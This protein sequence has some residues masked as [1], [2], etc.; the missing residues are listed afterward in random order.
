MWEKVIKIIWAPW[1]IGYI[2]KAK[3]GVKEECFLC[4]AWKGIDKDK[5]GVYKGKNAMIIMN[6]YP[7]NSG[8]IMIF[9]KTHTAEIKDISLEERI[10]IFELIEISI[11]ALRDVIKPQGFNI[12]VNLGR[13]A[14]AGLEEHI[15]IHIVPR[16]T[17][18]TNFMS[19]IGNS[20]VIVEDI[21]MTT[22]K[23]KDALA[24][25][26]SERIKKLKN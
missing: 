8:H 6:K 12:G 26:I 18:D 9:P 11:E 10:E 21:M 4:D 2:E 16:W 25:V 7:Y 15:H 17:G 19:V 5:L 23:I 3:S 20:K 14:G 24:N 22:R 13:P 1:R